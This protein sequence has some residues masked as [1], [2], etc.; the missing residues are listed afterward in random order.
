MTTPYPFHPWQLLKVHVKEQ[1]TTE[2]NV[3][4]TAMENALEENNNSGRSNIEQVATEVNVAAI[5]VENTTE[6]DIRSE[7]SST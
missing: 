6:E 2:A 3:A 1:V 4:T 5:A 7:R